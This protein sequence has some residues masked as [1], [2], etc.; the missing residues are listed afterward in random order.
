MVGAT[1]RRKGGGII[2]WEGFEGLT[3]GKV[4]GLGLST[5]S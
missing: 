3:R 5:C 1:E 4:H 2:L